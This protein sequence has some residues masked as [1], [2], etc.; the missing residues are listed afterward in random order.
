[1]RWFETLSDKNDPV[2][3]LKSMEAVQVDQPQQ[4]EQSRTEFGRMSPES[5]RELFAEIADGR[6]AALERLYDIASHRLFGLALW[7]TGSQ[8]DACDVVQEVIVRVAEQ[9][10][11]LA[12][13]KNPR[14]WLLTVA[15]R[16]SVDVIRR[17]RRRPSEPL[18]E[19]PFLT[20][21]EVQ[22]GRGVDARR[23]SRLLARLPSAQRDAVY[24]REFAD[25]TYFDIGKIV[26][27]PTFTAASRYRIGI[28]KL[29]RLVEDSS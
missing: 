15:Y 19:H 8:E 28:R 21:P 20:A 6:V 2:A 14:A 10:H 22:P 23:V 16:L 29:R 3:R 5:W 13:V 12:R 11:R 1:V 26:G 9:R 17:H 18:E 7:H 27:V 25:C 24:L 4:G